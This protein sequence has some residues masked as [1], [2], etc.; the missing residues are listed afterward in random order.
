MK[1]ELAV[2]VV[3][4]AGG[5]GVRFWPRST[6]SRPKQFLPLT[7]DRTMLQLTYARFRQWLPESAIFIATTKRYFPLVQEQLPHMDLT[8]MIVEPVQ[9]DTAPCT[10]LAA[11]HFLKKGDDEVLVTVP[12]DQHVPD[13]NSLKEALMLAETAAAA[14]KNIITLGVTP[15]RPE[16]GYGY[17]K[18]AGVRKNGTLPVERFIEKPSAEQ[19]AEFIQQGNVFW[20][21]GIFIWK[22]ST[23]AHYMSV[24]Q[25]ELWSALTRSGKAL[26]EVYSMLPKISVDYA[27]MEKAD[28]I[29]TVPVDFEWDDVGTWTSLERMHEPDDSGNVV[30]GDVRMEDCKDS[31]IYSEN[32]RT[33]VIGA[34]D[35]IVISTGDG[36]LVCHKSKEQL[37]KKVLQSLDREEGG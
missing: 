16:T 12:S 9:K 1:G 6:V 15:T 20:N 4:M 32:V 22:P 3:I 29:Y 19:A 23:I 5:K 26:E 11:L 30:K 13:A 2:K 14:G 18:T 10:A 21:S 33:V 7:S 28:T 27:I 36:L 37:I 35:L 31:I 8:Q 25:P 17:M 34:E 24:L